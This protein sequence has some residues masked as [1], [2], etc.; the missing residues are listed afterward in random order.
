[1][2][3]GL[4][5]DVHVPRTVVLQLRSRGVDVLASC[6]LRKLDEAEWGGTEAALEGLRENDVKP[7]ATKS[8]NLFALVSRRDTQ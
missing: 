3:V 4:Y 8:I 1:M 7:V 6:R 2:L 5:A